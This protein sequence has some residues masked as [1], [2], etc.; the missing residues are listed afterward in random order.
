MTYFWNSHEGFARLRGTF[1]WQCCTGNYESVWLRGQRQA[2]CW[3][4]RTVDD[5]MSRQ[6]A[7]RQPRIATL[8]FNQ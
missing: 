6:V 2:Y 4:S 5:E 7:L 1:L 8:S 3:Q